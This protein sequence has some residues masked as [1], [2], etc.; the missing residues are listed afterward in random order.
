MVPVCV[1]TAGGAAGFLFPVRVDAP[2]GAKTSAS[3]SYSDKSSYGDQSF[4]TTSSVGDAKPTA[5]GAVPTAFPFPFSL[6]S[7]YAATLTYVGFSVC[8]V[9]E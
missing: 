2:R 9:V 6:G 5:V 3:V 8:V 4:I 1:V 7:A